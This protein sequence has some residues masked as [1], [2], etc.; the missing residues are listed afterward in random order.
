MFSARGEAGYRSR[1]RFWRSGV[2]IP[3]GGPKSGDKIDASCEKPDII[4][5]FCYPNE[6]FSLYWNADVKSPFSLCGSTWTPENKY[7]IYRQI[8]IK[9]LFAFLLP[10]KGENRYATERINQMAQ[11]SVQHQDEWQR[12][13]GGLLARHPPMRKYH[14]EERILYESAKPLYMKSITKNY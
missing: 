5:L 12:M 6:D 1:F 10:G 3:P 8:E 14:V 7:Q 4:G 9:N 11:G 13:A 2:R